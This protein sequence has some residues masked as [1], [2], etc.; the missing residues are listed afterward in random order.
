MLEY[1]DIM[2]VAIHE[3]SHMICPL[4]GHGPLFWKINLT[5][6]YIAYDNGFYSYKNYNKNPI[7]VGKVLLN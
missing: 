7:Y 3:T 6:L 4:Y 2:Y 5:L 1:D